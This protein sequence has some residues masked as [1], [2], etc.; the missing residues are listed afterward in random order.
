MDDRVIIK[1]HLTPESGLGAEKENKKIID[2][3][4]S[5]RYILIVLTNFIPKSDIIFGQTR[6]GIAVALHVNP[7]MFA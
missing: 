7:H 3:F 2:D 6:I 1:M 4:L 5:G